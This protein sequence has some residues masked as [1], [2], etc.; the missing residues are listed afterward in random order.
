[1]GKNIFT[2]TSIKTLV[3]LYILLAISASILIYS[4]VMV[5]S[6]THQKS[7]NYD[8]HFRYHIANDCFRQGADLLT[9]AVRRYVVT[10]KPEYIEAYFHEALVERHRDR[11]LEMIRDMQISQSLKDSLAYAM[12]SSDSLMDTEYHAM[13]LIAL[14]SDNETLH[15]EVKEYPLTPEEEKMTIDQRHDLAEH[16]L[17]DDE[18]VKNKADIY[19]YLVRGLE[20]ASAQS[21][22]RHLKLRK[23]LLHTL[24]LGAVSLTALVLSICGFIFYRRVQHEHMMEEQAKENARMNAELKEEHSR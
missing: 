15:R 18:Y 2:F 19:S 20:E 17:W 1:M 6:I 13:H 11:A 5:N 16:L 24:F 9:E 10:M 21:M 12:K 4:A 22:K 8:N 7:V 3:M 23:E 14:K